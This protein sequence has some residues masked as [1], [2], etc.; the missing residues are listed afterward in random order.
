VELAV[1]VVVEKVT[2]LARAVLVAAVA[3]WVEAA[4][5]SVAAG[6]L[7]RFHP[8]TRRQVASEASAR[9]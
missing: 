8:E 9:V 6:R 5:A 1:A 2:L 3:T 4:A 7:I